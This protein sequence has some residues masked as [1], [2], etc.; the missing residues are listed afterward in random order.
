MLA[1]VNY[2]T[3]EPSKNFKL[4]ETHPKVMRIVPT[5]PIFQK[6]HV[7]TMGKGKMIKSH[8]SNISQIRSL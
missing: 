2:R 8:K 5:I 6:Q 1:K 7:L 4:S 3:F